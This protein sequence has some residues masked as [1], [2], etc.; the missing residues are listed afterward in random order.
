MSAELEKNGQGVR[1]IPGFA[2]CEEKHRLMSEFLEAIH[3][4]TTLQS[5]QTEA[6]I[7]G[8]P[9]IARFD[10]LLRLAQEKK[11][12]AQCAWIA[13][14]ESH[15]CGG[16]LLE[17]PAAKSGEAAAHSCGAAKSL[18]DLHNDALVAFHRALEMLAGIAPGDPAY[19]E[20]YELREV[21]FRDVL[22]TG[23]QYWEAGCSV[24][25]GGMS[26]DIEDRRT[27]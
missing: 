7:F 14:L 5:Q 9:D 8:D 4:V 10:G 22:K 12:N 17:C 24:D 3:A 27:G 26:G 20:V 15:Q 11:E 18:L 16:D 13:H 2:F 23:R 21:A 6:V 25:S 1:Q 19:L